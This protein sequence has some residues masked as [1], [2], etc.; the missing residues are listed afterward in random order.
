MNSKPQQEEEEQQQQQPIVFVTG[1]DTDVGK[2]FV[3]A[4]LVH[5]WKAAYWKPAQIGIESDQGDSETLKNFKVAASTWQP[6]IFTPTY[7]LQ[8]PLSPLQAMEY[9]PGV[10]IKLLDFAVPDEWDAESPLVVEGAGGVCVPITRKLEI[11]TDLI[12]HLIET[13]SHPVYVVVVTRS[14]LGTLNH[15]L[16]TW[17]HLCDNGLR[18]HLFG[19]ILN[20]EPNEGNVQVLEKFGVDV[21]AQVGQC[22]T[23]QNLE[24]ALHGLPTVESLVTQQDR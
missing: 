1:T 16:L 19:V 12:K 2:T 21:I 20:G 3:S 9:E 23:A 4:L 24:M 17:N 6:R 5:K 13:S 10:D 7:V 11:T 22:A 15:T 8:K 14:G 18:G